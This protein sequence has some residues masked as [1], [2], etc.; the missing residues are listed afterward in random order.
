MKKNYSKRS[1]LV[2][3]VF[4]I[5]M[6]AAIPAFAATATVDVRFVVKNQQG[7]YKG[8]NI[9][10]GN[11]AKNTGNNGTVEFRLKNVPVT[12]MVNAFLID[13]NVPSG[14]NCDVNLALGAHQD[15]KVNSTSPGSCSLDI[16]FTEHTQ[17]IVIEYFVDNNFNYGY[18]N[19]T[20]EQKNGSNPPPPPPPPNPQPQGDPNPPPQGDPNPPPPPDGH[21]PDMLP[22]E[23]HEEYNEEHFEGMPPEEFHED[24]QPEE[25]REDMAPDGFDRKPYTQ[26]MMPSYV[27]III[28]IGVLIVLAIAALIVVL[29]RRR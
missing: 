1:I 13:P 23:N 4:L 28:T 5:I 15:V 18:S 27:W 21:D 19:A 10:F 11:N 6:F 26:P 16:M 24:M 20:F 7:P 17:T 14:Y 29:I 3:L 9:Q 25:F 2:T 8:V 22:E 12:T